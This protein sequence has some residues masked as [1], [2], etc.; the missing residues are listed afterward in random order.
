[1]LSLRHHNQ[2]KES[3]GE[4]RARR[5]SRGRRRSRE[6]GREGKRTGLP[7]LFFRLVQ[8]KEQAKYRT[9][10]YRVWW[11]ILWVNLSGPQGQD[12]GISIIGAISGK[13]ILDEINI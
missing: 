1:M 4:E 3:R 6:R 8:K 9:P 13:E 10:L 11:L 7:W 2:R 5:R 12:I